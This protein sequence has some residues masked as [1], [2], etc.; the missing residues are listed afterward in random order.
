[1]PFTRDYPCPPEAL[2]EENHQFALKV[3]LRRWSVPFG[4]FPVED[5][6]NIPKTSCH[7]D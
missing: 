3:S 1:M 2:Q 4:G 6:P 7:V 5:F